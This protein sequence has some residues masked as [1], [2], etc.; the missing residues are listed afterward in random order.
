MDVCYGEAY[1]DIG[2]GGYGVKE[3]RVDGGEDDRDIL[4]MYA[5]MVRRGGGVFINIL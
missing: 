2:A 3:C 5:A 4:G 1:H